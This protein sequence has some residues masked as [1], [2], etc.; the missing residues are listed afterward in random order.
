MATQLNQIRPYLNKLFPPPASHAGCQ[1]QQSY[2]ISQKKK[3]INKNQS[4]ENKLSNNKK[5]SY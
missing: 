3:R 2:V 4:I 1:L 5:N